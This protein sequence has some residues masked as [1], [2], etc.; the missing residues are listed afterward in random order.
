MIRPAK[1]DDSYF[2]GGG[3]GVTYPPQVSPLL[4]GNIKWRGEGG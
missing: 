3:G 1:P 4:E 2:G